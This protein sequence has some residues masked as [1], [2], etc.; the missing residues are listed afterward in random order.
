MVK[1]VFNPKNEN[2][3][4]PPKSKISKRIEKTEIF[5]PFSSIEQTNEISETKTES[6]VKCRDLIGLENC[7]FIL[8]KWF[9]EQDGILLLIGPTGCGKTTLVNLFCEEENIKLLNIKLNNDKSKRDILKDIDLFLEYS[10]DF[11]F[12]FKEFKRLILIDEY[13]NGQNDIMGISDII[14]LKE[15]YPKVNI[16]IISSDAK[17]S[18][19]S[20]LK[21]NCEVYYIN[22][23]PKSLIKSWVTSLNYDLT[24]TQLNYVLNN[25]GSDKR[26]IINILDF[27]KNSSNKLNDL[28]SFL[29]TYY[30]DPDINIFDFIKE[31]FDEE[32]PFDL[33]GIFKIYDN[34]GFALSN[35]VHESYL[36]YNQNIDNIAK[37]AESI[38]Y[39]EILFS[40]TYES[41][42]TFLPDFHC[43]NSIIIPSFY[44]RN[45]FNCKPRSSVINNR[46]NILLNNK[47]I[48]AKINGNCSKLKLD[49]FDIYT[50]KKILNQ[51]LIK[52]K[53]KSKCIELKIEFIKNV[54][55]QL[56]DSIERLELIYKHFSD[57][58]ESVIKEVKT[59]NFT[60]KFKEKIKTT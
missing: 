2:G 45:N 49:I 21:K 4:D 43:L 28:N 9:Y 13:Q 50:I 30:K 33:N 48:I 31:L 36:D 59:K 19:L 58:K 41:N 20:D 1:L 35:L 32:I 3:N 34:D 52:G 57:F 38:S 5:N 25:C 15:K 55:K 47:K 24:T 39:G 37:S 7:H 11:F 54:V 14:G 27:L 17:G 44:S 40:D 46:F 10:F 51:E 8:K 26:I 60:L 42:K 12:S 53:S 23:I 29:E 6:L 22:E 16:L 56:N 18:K